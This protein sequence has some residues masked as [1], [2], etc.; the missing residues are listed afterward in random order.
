MPAS[1][2]Q[3]PPESIRSHLDKVLASRAFVGSRRLQTFLRWISE[4][5][6]ADDADSI[7]EYRLGVEVFERGAGFDPRTDS[8]VRVEANRLRHKLRE[9]YDSEGRDDGMRIDLPKG[10]YAPVFRLIPELESSLVPEPEPALQEAR[11]APLLSPSRYKVWLGAAFGG[12]GLAALAI[13]TIIVGGRVS[14]SK[15]VPE[16]EAG[17]DCVAVLPF[18]NLSGGADNER[19]T[20]GFAEELTNRLAR[21]GELRVA[22]RRSAFQFKNKPYDDRLIGRQLRVG[23]LIEGSLRRE[24]DHLQVTVELISARDGYHVW[25]DRFETELS[26]LYS[27]ETDIL[28]GVLRSIKISPQGGLERV[29]HYAAPPDP[30]AHRL[31]L[32]ARFYWNQRTYEAL[33]QAIALY[34]QAIGKDPKY[35]L[36]Y[37]GVAECYGVIAA[38]GLADPRQAAAKGK[39]A[40][41]KA[42]GI[43]SGVAEAYGALGLIR[44]VGDWDWQGAEESFQTA[45]TLNPNYASAYQWRAHNLLWQGRFSEAH[46]QI[47]KASALDSLS[48]VILS[49]RAEFA[50]YMR[51]FAEALRLYD[52]VLKIDP[53]FISAT[54]ERGMVLMQLRKYPDAIACFEKARRLT[55]EE[56]SPIV[57]LASVYALSGNSLEA[58]RLFDQLQAP[59]KGVHVSSLQFATIYA[60]LGEVDHGIAELEKAY[61]AHDSFLFTIKVHPELD[62]LRGAPGFVSLL[63]KMRLE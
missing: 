60:S 40:A 2:A 7:K 36:A 1:V 41:L 45:I 18:Q 6:L 48:L 28:M 63:K 58:R 39:Q 11:P 51:N 57:G 17:I 25:S 56:A 59:V 35:A 4:R 15:N 27:L 12:I 42:I 46:D 61:Q 29:M 9:Y 44:S 21:F 22:A 20:D 53:N 8:I 38:N 19:L 30:E 37:A 33:Q 32:E 10:S 50:Y 26:G 31:Y 16:P 54:I 43:D 14:L 3:P 49:N 23:S 34:Q 62:P 13:A 55:S 52:E 47:E 5:V 24:G